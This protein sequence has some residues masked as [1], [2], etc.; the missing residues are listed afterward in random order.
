MLILVVI[1]LMGLLGFLILKMV[2][3]WCILE[4]IVLAALLIT[5]IAGGCLLQDASCGESTTCK[6]PIP[7]GIILMLVSV[8]GILSLK[9]FVP[10]FCV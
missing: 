9:M 1:A 6:K 8:T 7:Y 4:F 5:G 2:S 3:I 10:N